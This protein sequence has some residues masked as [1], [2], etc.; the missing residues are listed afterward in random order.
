MQSFIVN[1]HY[2]LPC[3]DMVSLSGIYSYLSSDNVDKVANPLEVMVGS[4]SKSF[5]R[6]QYVEGS[7]HVFVTPVARFSFGYGNTLQTFVDGG[8]ETNHR[9]VL[10]AN[11]AF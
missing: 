9:F 3:L 10:K 8:H 7:L 5:L 1:L 11:Y 6:Q 2:T 4:F